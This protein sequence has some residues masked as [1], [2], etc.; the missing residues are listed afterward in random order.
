M[1][2]IWGKN[3]KIS[4]FGES[5]GK[6][7]GVTI[8]GLPAGILLNM[9]QIEKLMNERAPGRTPWSTPRKEEDAVDIICGVNNGYT[10]GTPLTT[11]TKSTDYEKTKNIIRPSH[12]DYTGNVRYKGHNI[13]AGGGHFSGRLTAPLVFAGAVVMQI[14]AQKGISINARIYSV[15]EIKD[16]VINYCTAFLPGQILDENFPTVSEEKKNEM[17]EYV[18]E[19]KKQNDSTGGVVEVIINSLPA[20]IGSPI[21]DNLESNIASIMFA[22]PGVKGVEFGAGFAIS[23]QK[24][25]LA[26]DEFNVTDGKVVT[27]TTN[28]G[29]ILGGISSGMPV[30]VRCAIKPTPSIAMEQNSVDIE[31][32]EPA[33]LNIKGR[34]DPCIVPRAVPVLKAAAAIAVLDT[35]LSQAE[36]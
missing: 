7:V 4:I 5:H 25:S 10:T 1:S 33:K 17:I 9:D 21:F 19:C 27:T 35:M 34:H 23:T 29:G 30:V 3:I 15:G 36:I 8:D 28:N 11:N 12:A 31:K 14:L 2:S 13:V 26:N 22:V 20:G 24:A 6:A 16:E 32:M 18:L